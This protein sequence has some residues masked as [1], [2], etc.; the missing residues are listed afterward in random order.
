MNYNGQP[1]RTQQEINA[2]LLGSDDIGT[3]TMEEIRLSLL[4]ENQICGITHGNIWS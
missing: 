4:Q 1:L 2:E 3:H